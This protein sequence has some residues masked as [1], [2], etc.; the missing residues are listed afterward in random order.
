MQEAEA[1]QKACNIADSLLGRGFPVISFDSIAGMIVLRF[2]NG[3]GAIHAD[4]DTASAEG[5]VEAYQK[6]EKDRPGHG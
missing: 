1:Y 4:A 6:Y 5:F 2:G 3:I